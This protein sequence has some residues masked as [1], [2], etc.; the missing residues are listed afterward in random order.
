VGS[1]G[2]ARLFESEDECSLRVHPAEHMANDPVFARRVKP[3]QHHQKGL[4][5]VG[6]EQVLQLAHAF[7]MGL[8]FGESLFLALLLARITA[9][10]LSPGSPPLTA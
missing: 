2:L 10:R 9:V 8:D 4:V 3:P 7:D 5:V 6:V 1:L